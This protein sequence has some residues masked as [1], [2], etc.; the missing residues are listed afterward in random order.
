MQMTIPIYRRT[1]GS[2]HESASNGNLPE[3]QAILKLYLRKEHNMNYPD[4][5]PMMLG[6]MVQTGLDHHLGLHDYSQE[7]GQQEGLEIN[8]AI[9]E[10]L[11][12][13][14]VYTPRTWDNGKDQSAYDSFQ[15]FLPDMVKCAAEGLKQYFQNVNAIEGE[16]AQ[17][18]NEPLI[19]VPILFYQDYSGGG[20]QIDLK[21]QVPRKNPTKKDGTFTYS[22]PKPKTEPSPAWIR[23]QA[24]YWKATG[25]KPALLCVSAKDYHIIDETNCEQLQDDYLQ[26]AYDDMVRSWLVLQ[27]KLKD[28]QG[29]WKHIVERTKLDGAEILNRYGPDIYK[30]SQQLWSIK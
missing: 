22:A 14:Q 9:R 12:E 29:S 30:L 24:V 26:V 4:A 15:D 1:F 8:K 13:Y 10:A 6:R 25:Q 23:Q 5:A 2:L 7:Q 20:K 27:N 28:S 11:T 21:C 19:D 3:D 18:Y 17:R 16:F